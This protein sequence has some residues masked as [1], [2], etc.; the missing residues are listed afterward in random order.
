M[1]FLFPHLSKEFLCGNSV[2]R[3]FMNQEIPGILWN[4]KVISMFVRAQLLFISGAT[5]IQLKP[6]YAISCICILI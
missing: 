5:L 1:K 4:L 3:F 6:Y 2:S